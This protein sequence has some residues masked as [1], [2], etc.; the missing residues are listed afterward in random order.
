MLKT[1][2]MLPLLLS[3]FTSRAL[4]QTCSELFSTGADAYNFYGTLTNSI[5]GSEK[6]FNDWLIVHGFRYPPMPE[7][8]EGPN[9]MRFYNMDQVG[10]V[11]SEMRMNAKTQAE[12]LK[13]IEPQ[14]ERE[15]FGVFYELDPVYKTADVKIAN[16]P[17]I[18]NN[19]VMVRDPRTGATR[20]EYSL[21]AQLRTLEALEQSGISAES[22]GMDNLPTL[23]TFQPQPLRSFRAERTGEVREKIWTE[24]IKNDSFYKDAA[25]AAA[26]TVPEFLKPFIK[27]I[28]SDSGRTIVQVNTKA[29]DDYSEQTVRALRMFV[30]T[31][32][33]AYQRGYRLKGL[34]PNNVGSSLGLLTEW[35]DS[36]QMSR[37]IFLDYDTQVWNA[38]LYAMKHDGQIV[39]S[40]W[41]T[42][43][44]AFVAF[45]PAAGVAVKWTE[46]MMINGYNLTRLFQNRDPDPLALIGPNKRKQKDFYFFLGK[47]LL[48]L[49]P[50]KRIYVEAHTREHADLYESTYKFRRY[51]VINDFDWDVMALQLYS[52]VAR[53]FWRVKELLGEEGSRLVPPPWIVWFK[54]SD[55]EPI[56]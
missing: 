41:R 49:D 10:S 17:G 54:P 12:Q 55:R 2:L 11:T 40:R 16:H 22:V 32:W 38:L 42:I 50:Q 23:E 6:P 29:D 31:H 33:Q 39:H 37:Q 52:S 56:F 7:G 4:A 21:R 18:F 34:V 47:V 27:I 36:L 44:D 14:L 8:V 24:Q 53:V 43:E 15:I 1:L 13:I 30:I 3:T 20:M 5:F 28:H 25:T 9:E 45:Y 26:Q 19:G 46:H 51:D 35:T 48:T